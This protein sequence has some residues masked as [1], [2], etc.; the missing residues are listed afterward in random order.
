MT[1]KTRPQ[2]V[3]ELACRDATSSRK[4]YVEVLGF[5]VLY[6]RPDQGFCYLE[7]HGVE[8]MIG[9]LSDDSWRS[10]EMQP[11]FG[12]G[13]HFQIMTDGVEELHQN[14]SLNSVKVSE[15]WRT[16]GI[17]QTTITLARDSLLS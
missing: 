9:Q 7:R 12:R 4:F 10:G 3:P 17:V 16:H 13:M 6:E 2:L 14:C 1:V 11:P 5:S 8:I 15:N